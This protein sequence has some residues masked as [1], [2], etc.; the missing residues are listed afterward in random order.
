MA[1]MKGRLLR[2]AAVCGVLAGGVLVPATAAQAY[3]TNCSGAYAGNGYRVYCGQGNGSFRAGISCTR[4]GGSTTVL[5]YGSWQRANG[6]VWSV[7]NCLSSED[8]WGG[9]WSLSNS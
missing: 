4:I 8:A 6:G 7:A 2:T 1:R 5:R 9:F 3:P